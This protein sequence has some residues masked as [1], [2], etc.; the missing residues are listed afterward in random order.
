MNLATREDVNH[1][2]SGST[3]RDFLKLSSGA[4]VCLSG[5]R[6]ASSDE[7]GPVFVLSS[8]RRQKILGWG[9]FPGWVAWDE[10][11]GTDKTLQDAVYREL[12]INVVRIPVMPEYAHRDGSLNIKLIDKYLVTQIETALRYGVRKWIVTT[13]SPPS[14]MKTIDDDRDTVNGEANHLKPEC[15]DD[16]VKYYA[17]VL[18]Y[19]RDVK[20]L[21][22][23]LYAS[24]QNEPD[25]MVTWPGCVYPPAQWRRVV[26]KFRKAL[27]AEKLSSIKI[28]GTDHNHDTLRKYFGE[29]LAELVSDPGLFRAMDG[30]AFHSYNEGTDSGGAAAVDARKEILKFKNVLKLGSE[31]WMTENCTT[32]SEDF[33]DSA[34]RHLRSMMRDLGYLESNYYLYW[35]G[36]S[37]K[38][39]FGGEELIAHGTK[40]KLFFVFQKLWHIVAPDEFS[41][42]TFQPANAADLSTYGPDPMDMLAF[43]GKGKSVIL[44]TNESTGAKN[45]TLSNLTGTRITIHRT[46]ENEDMSAVGTQPILSGD[47][48]LLLPPRSILLCE[49]DCGE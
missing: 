45:L 42:R 47:T 19:L 27:D 15:E 30:I 1:R 2:L 35:L 4:V 37:D 48:S 11:I 40:T 17:C 44:L 12:G 21:P 49:T 26:K 20:S 28:H 7:P 23:P 36:S 25:A 18:A 43:T 32:I 9:C 13:W 39:K 10:K 16:F 6:R 34:I 3:R 33:T 24:V 38:E 8:E 29:G 46:S 22:L 41:V 31:I 5:A 14:F